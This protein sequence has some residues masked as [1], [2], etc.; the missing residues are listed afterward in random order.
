MYKLT[1]AFIYQPKPTFLHRLD[2]RAKLFMVAAFFATSFLIGNLYYLV[3]LLELEALIAVSASTLKRWTRSIAAVAPFF[4]FIFIVNYL[5]EQGLVGSFLPAIKLI[6][7]VGIFSLFFITTAPDMFALMLDKLGLPQ[8]ISLAFSMAL[9]FVP[10]LAQQTQD[11]I[12]AQ[13]SRG[14]SV[15]SRNPLKRIRALVPIFIPIIILSIKRSIEVAEALESRAFDPSRPRSSWI[16][17]KMG[18]WD[19]AFAAS[20]GV[21][22][23]LSIFVF[24]L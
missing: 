21:F 24:G 14:L 12:D 22:V 7:L 16:E 8:I 5:T 3:L 4:L 23:V 18:R 13:R 10:V 20:N 1:S 11:I 19:W 2:P 9:R 6:I 17:L 15:D